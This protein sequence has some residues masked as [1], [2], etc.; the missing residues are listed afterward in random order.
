M[1]EE[2]NRLKELDKLTPSNQIKA[3]TS[4]EDVVN[5]LINHIDDFSIP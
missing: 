1:E 4:K 5:K 2:Q 3:T